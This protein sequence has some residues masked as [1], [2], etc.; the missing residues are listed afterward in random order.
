M[1]LGLKFQ[2]ILIPNS[3]P[4]YV[5]L[6]SLPHLQLGLPHHTH[7]YVQAAEDLIKETEI[8]KCNAFMTSETPALA[9]VLIAAN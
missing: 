7:V 5:T 9:G 3:K 2:I 8:N 4:D 6:Y 1:I